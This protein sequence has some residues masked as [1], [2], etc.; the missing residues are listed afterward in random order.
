[1]L[2]IANSHS[3]QEAES[4]TRRLCTLVEQVLQSNQNLAARINGLER[5][6]SILSE[7]VSRIEPRDD[8]STVRQTRI[9][10]A[11]SFIETEGDALRFTFEQDLYA[12]RVYN[13]AVNRHSISSLTSTALY[14]TAMSVFSKLSLSQVSNIS[15]YALPVYAFDLV[16]S[17]CYVFGEEGA[18]GD[19]VAGDTSRRDKADVDKS[20]SNILAEDSDSGS[21]VQASPNLQTLGRLLGRFGRRKRPAITAPQAPVWVNHVGYDNETGQFTVCFLHT[22]DSEITIS[23]ARD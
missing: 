3:M 2:I 21:S 17:G 14:A 6:G 9:S 12:S 19:P 1:M 18:S 20:G 7:G 5:E 13:K 8:A 23:I 16:N 22:M 10:K 15:F 4:S 11:F